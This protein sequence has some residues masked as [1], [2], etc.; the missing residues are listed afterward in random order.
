MLNAIKP[1]TTG[2]GIENEEVRDSQRVTKAMTFI[3]VH[4]RNKSWGRVLSLSKLTSFFLRAGK[5]LTCL[6]KNRKTNVARM[7]YMRDEMRFEAA[8]W[9]RIMSGQEKVMIN[10]KN[11]TGNFTEHLF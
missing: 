11:N 7:K 10:V 4:D 6:R 1:Y 5:I 3:Q 8:I 2:K 9:V